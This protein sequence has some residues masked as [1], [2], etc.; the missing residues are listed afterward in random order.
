MLLTYVYNIVSGAHSVEVKHALEQACYGTT[1]SVKH[2][3]KYCYPRPHIPPVY[4]IVLLGETHRKQYKFMLPYCRQIPIG[5]SVI[6]G[7]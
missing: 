2:S 6:D 1:Q 7:A 5:S 3:I 4:I